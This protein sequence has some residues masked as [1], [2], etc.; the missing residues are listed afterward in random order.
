MID[1]IWQISTRPKIAISQNKNADGL[2]RESDSIMK[3]YA[4]LFVLLVLALAL[5][6]TACN[7]APTDDESAD[8]IEVIDGYLVVNGEKTEHKVHTDPV[9]FVI[10]GYVAV[11]GVKTEYKVDT[12]DVIEVIDGYLVVNGVKTEYIA[13]ECNHVWETT[14]TPPTCSTGGFDTLTCKLCGKEVVDNE[15]A[16]LEHTFTSTYS[17]DDTYH[18]FDCI[19]CS[20]TNGKEM[21]TPDANDNCTVCGIPLSATP[22]VIYDKSADGTYA[23]VVAYNGTATKVKIASEYQGLPV[24]NIYDNA[25]E[26]NITIKVVIIPDSVTSIGSHAFFKCAALTSIIIPYSVKSIG[27]AAFWNCSL[28]TSVTIPNSVTSIGAK[29]FQ[30]CYKLARVTIGNSVTTIGEE[31]FDRCYALI[32]VIIPD[33][34]TYIGDSAFSNCNSA[35]Y[36]EYNLCKYIGDLN[37]PHKVLVEVTNKNL[38]TYEIHEN[39]RI[40][41]GNAF[42]GC[43][44]LTSITIPEE[45]TSIG[46][47]AFYYCSALTSVTIPSSVMSIGECAFTFCSALTTIKFNGTV[48]QWNAVSLG[49][50]WNNSGRA[51]EVI[52]SDGTVTLE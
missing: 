11:N 43:S 45:V 9:I 10:D 26:N 36:T 31:A 46:N 2:K 12:D 50:N 13:S 8:I 33:S 51:T 37:N 29:A 52:C 23:E 5:T 35:L 25:F 20:E 32:N 3:K 41:A 30:H 18:W 39:T 4:S 19:G 14:T 6:L 48:E 27:A 47:M 7:N 49:N 42:D 40:I 44:K 28:L 16:K 15:T 1:T 17:F 38:S 34:V 24:K 22:G 21:H